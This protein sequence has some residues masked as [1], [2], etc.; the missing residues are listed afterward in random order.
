MLKKKKMIKLI[1]MID[2]VLENDKKAGNGGHYDR[3]VT[4]ANLL[5][6]KLALRM[7]VPCNQAGIIL[8]EPTLQ[9]SNPQIYDTELFE[10]GHAQKNKIFQ[11]FSLLENKT[12]YV[13]YNLDLDIKVSFFR[14]GKPRT[15]KT[16]NDLVDLGI[17][18]NEENNYYEYLK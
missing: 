13:A 17:P 12:G 8:Q 14:N 1:S 6:K 2:F 7:F 11:G 10:Y 5:K 16:V 9:Y 4:Y 3:L 15:F 18:I